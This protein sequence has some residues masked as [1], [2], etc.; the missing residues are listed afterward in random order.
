MCGAVRARPRRA[1]QHAPAHPSLARCAAERA[2]CSS[3]TAPSLFVL[4]VPTSAT[5]GPSAKLRVERV[6][7]DVERVHI[8]ANNPLSAYT[9]RATPIGETP[10]AHFPASTRSGI[11][12]IPVCTVQKYRMRTHALPHHSFARILSFKPVSQACLG[13]VRAL[14]DCK[15]H[16]V[17]L[18]MGHEP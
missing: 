15:C 16:A 17:D 3:D 1:A 9:K 5:V 4:P 7:N 2:A 14:Q 11:T 13:C 12:D 8:R 18:E 6:V 10:T